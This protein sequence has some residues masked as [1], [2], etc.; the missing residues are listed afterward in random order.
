M[1]TVAT[2]VASPRARL[3]A[4][5][6]PAA[7]RAITFALGGAL[8]LFLIVLATWHQ[9]RG[10]SKGFWM[11]EGLSVGIASHPFTAIPSV[12]QQDGSPPLY[13]MLLHV[14]MNVFG[15]TEARTH[16]LSALA[17]VAMVPVGL[18]AGWSIFTPRVGWVCALLCALNPFLT[19]YGGETRMYS[20]LALFG[21]TT[22][23]LIVLVFV[24]RRRRWAIPCA[25]SLAAMIYTHGWGLFMGVGCFV[26]VLVLFRAQEEERKGMLVDGLISFG[27][28]ALLFA[29]WLPTLLEQ[30]RHT[31][32]PWSTAPR[33]GAPIQISRGLMG[34]DR[35]AVPL[36]VGG[37]FGLAQVLR[38]KEPSTLPTAAPSRRSRSSSSSRSS[39]P[40][41]P[42]SSRRRGPRATS[43]SSTG[44]CCCSPRSGSPARA[45]SASPSWRSRCFF[46][47]LPN[48]YTGGVKSDNCATSP[49]RSGR[50]CAPA[51]SSSP[52]S[53]SRCRRWPTT[54]ARTSAT[55]RP[56]WARCRP[57]PT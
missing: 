30:S 57:T 27:G 4:A 47:I 2:A 14:W 40:G 10:L 51:T 6:R 9:T 20:L 7:S 56:S 31:A 23:T 45:A 18:W 38:S 34:G 35:A 42:R 22:T 48:Q 37:G 13:Y 12:L 1:P 19:Y 44:R 26:A 52:A 15:T 21:L 3:R 16:M 46:W 17:A 53:P 55:R 25:L 32:A 5:R 11:D 33:L 43:A 54:S 24:L 28:A 29:P 36:L 39:S 50:R 49:P 41:S 8:L